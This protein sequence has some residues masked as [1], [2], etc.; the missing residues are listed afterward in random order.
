MDAIKAIANWDG[1]NQCNHCEAPKRSQDEPLQHNKEGRGN[2]LQSH[3]AALPMNT[4]RASWGR[5][6]YHINT[7]P[8]TTIIAAR[9]SIAATG[10]RWTQTAMFCQPAQEPRV[11]RLMQRWQ[12]SS[13]SAWPTQ[14]TTT[15]G[16]SNNKKIQPPWHV[17]QASR[18]QRLLDKQQIELLGRA[19]DTVFSDKRTSA[20]HNHKKYHF[21]STSKIKRMLV[22]SSPKCK[23]IFGWLLHHRTSNG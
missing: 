5:C 19:S 10:A 3:K 7:H 4:T 15:T 22:V 2:Q 17:H 1:C 23:N 11:V 6:E 20:S 12:L 9:V 21:V 8:T 13:P 14:T 16:A 18:A